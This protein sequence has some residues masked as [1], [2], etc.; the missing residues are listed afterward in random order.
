MIEV[1]KRDALIAYRI[2]QAKEMLKDADLLIQNDS[3]RSAEQLVL[4]E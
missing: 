3:L 2:E 1:D 4:S